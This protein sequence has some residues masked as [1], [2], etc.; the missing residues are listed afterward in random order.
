MVSSY[1][2]YQDEDSSFFRNRRLSQLSQL[3]L[4][5][6]QLLFYEYF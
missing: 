5:S 2:F 6:M 1:S 4:N 3:R